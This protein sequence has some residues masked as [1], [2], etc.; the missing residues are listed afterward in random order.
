MIVKYFKA[1]VLDA[2]RIAKVEALDHL[3]WWRTP[4]ASHPEIAEKDLP[5][6][7]ADWKIYTQ[8]AYDGACA[9]VYS[10]DGD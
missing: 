7:F 2:Q 4:E 8:H 9:Y 5:A 10:R 1:D 6:D 3:D